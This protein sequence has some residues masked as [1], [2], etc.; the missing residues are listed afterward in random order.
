MKNVYKLNHFDESDF[1]DHADA[2]NTNPYG[3]VPGDKII[4]VKETTVF[5]GSGTVAA[6]RLVKAGAT[7]IVKAISPQYIDL[8]NGDYIVNN[9]TTYK[10]DNLLDSIAEIFTG[11][12]FTTAAKTAIAIPGTVVTATGDLLDVAGDKIASGWDSVS[13]VLDNLFGSLKW[14]IVAVVVIVVLYLIVKLNNK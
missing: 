10:R 6:T 8:N 12:P 5:N 1:Y 7:G 9:P 11:N 14:I 4:L 2:I 13:G 3:I